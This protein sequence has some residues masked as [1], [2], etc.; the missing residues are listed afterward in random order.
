MYDF[1]GGDALV[2]GVFGASIVLSIAVVGV[3]G[4]GGGGG[5]GGA[6]DNGFGAG[7]NGSDAEFFT[8]VLSLATRTTGGG[9]GGACSVRS[10][11]CSDF[12]EESVVDCSATDGAI[13]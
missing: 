5:G 6:A 7:D 3:S 13:S 9:G 12:E 2:V 1:S 11:T 8:K 10:E 4:C